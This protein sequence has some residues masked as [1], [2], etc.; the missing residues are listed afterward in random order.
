M[1]V[2]IMMEWKVIRQ[3]NIKVGNVVKKPRFHNTDK[4]KIEDRAESSSK[5][6][7]SIKIKNLYW[8]WWCEL[9][10]GWQWSGTTKADSRFDR[11]GRRSWWLGKEEWEEEGDNFASKELNAEEVVEGRVEKMKDVEWKVDMVGGLAEA[12]EEE[13]EAVR[14]IEDLIE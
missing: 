1:V 5:I 9:G 6:A 10:A 14:W 13:Q 4:I 7:V 8:T 12:K 2:I 11:T 3:S